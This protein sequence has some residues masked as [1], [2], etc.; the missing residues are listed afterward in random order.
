M[1]L[2]SAW[3]AQAGVSVPD[4]AARLGVAPS[5]V[6]RWRDGVKV[7]RPEQTAALAELTGGA[8]TADDH[9]AAYVA[10]KHTLIGKAAGNHAAVKSIQTDEIP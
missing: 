2:L 6:Y 10:R 4:V 3:L 1:T 7:P 9:H 5:T 8:V